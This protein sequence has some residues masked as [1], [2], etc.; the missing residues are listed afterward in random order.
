M[1]YV[2]ELATVGFTGRMLTCCSGWDSNGGRGK[3]N[4][5]SS[6]K[7]NLLSLSPSTD[8]LLSDDWILLNKDKIRHH[9]HPS[10]S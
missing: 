9:E 7:L 8:S 6:F 5:Q 3:G 10:N 1:A 2:V 4:T